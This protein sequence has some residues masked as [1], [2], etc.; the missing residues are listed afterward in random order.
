[1]M[2]KHQALINAFSRDPTQD[3]LR[4]KHSKNQT[5]HCEAVQ[6]IG[7]SWNKNKKRTGHPRSTTES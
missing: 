7:G 5:N 6:C 4:Q 2:Q 1:M 3:V